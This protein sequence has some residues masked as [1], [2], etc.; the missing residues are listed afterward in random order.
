MVASIKAN[1]EYINMA[2]SPDGRVLACGSSVGAK[3]D[4]VKDCI[5]LIDTRKHSTIEDTASLSRA[6]SETV[7]PV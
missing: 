5:S 2:W 7:S 1:H 4:T 3:D 6:H